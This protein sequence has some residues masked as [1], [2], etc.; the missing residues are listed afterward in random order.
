MKKLKNLDSRAKQFLYFIKPVLKRSALCFLCLL[1]FTS[2]LQAK[3][4]LE[5]PRRV[6]A[7]HINV[8]R[9][10]VCLSWRKPS[11][12]AISGYIIYRSEGEADDFDDIEELNFHTLQYCDSDVE[13]LKT[14]YYAISSR[15][16]AG[17]SKLS[18]PLKVKAKLPF[19]LSVTEIE[20]EYDSSENS[21]E[22][23]WDE[24]DYDYIKGFHVYRRSVYDKDWLR[25]TDEVIEGGEF[26]D[27]V[28]EE[29]RVYFYAVTVVNTE[30]REGAKGKSVRV[31][32]KSKRG[33]L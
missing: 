28:L 3:E 25:C 24:P 27:E 30:N 10:G 32:I 13:P 22:I 15:N 19:P 23:E 17:E 26:I 20:A 5:V 7:I 6:I 33:L 14:Y 16:T 29:G 4:P 2:V 1:I 31:L 12:N 9:K 8:T 18:Y 11:G 21:I